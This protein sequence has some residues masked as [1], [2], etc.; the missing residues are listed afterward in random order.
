MIDVD[1]LLSFHC[2]FQDQSVG[3]NIR[4]V[5]VLSRHQHVEIFVGRGSL[6][7]AFKVIAVDAER[8]QQLRLLSTGPY[9]HQ[10]GLRRGRE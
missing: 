9:P 6:E 4:L 1:L 2:A 5:A 8:S 3:W 7:A 10:I